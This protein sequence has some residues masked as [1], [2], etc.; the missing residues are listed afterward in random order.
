MKKRLFLNRVDMGGCDFA[1]DH[2]VE[3]ALDI[4]AGLAS[5]ILARGKDALIRAEM[6]AHHFSIEGIV[7]HGFMELSRVFFK[8]DG[9]FPGQDKPNTGGHND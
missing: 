6:A 4:F 2:G 5:A 1:V 8:S 7:I 9:S 3:F